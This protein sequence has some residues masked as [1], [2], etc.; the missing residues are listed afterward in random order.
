LTI[1]GEGAKDLIGGLGPHKRLGILVPGRNPRADVGL[2]GRDAGV[3][4]AL[5]QLGGQ[6]SKPA[7][8]L[9]EPGGAGR[10]EMHMEARARGQPPLD[11]LGLMRGV[12]VADQMDVE[13]GGN[14]LVEPGQE[15]LELC[16]QIQHHVRCCPKLD[17][18][19]LVDIVTRIAERLDRRTRYGNGER[20]FPKKGNE[21]RTSFG[22]F[23]GNEIRD[24]GSLV[25][26]LSLNFEL[27]VCFRVYCFKHTTMYKINEHT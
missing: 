17:D 13:V 10:D 27:H 18:P 24:F 16:N 6:L 7:L 26:K 20:H 14:F 2:Q 3:H 9:I 5:E 1:S 12:V 8:D 15:L 11:R 4:P 25:L 21:E 23:F 22:T 19:L